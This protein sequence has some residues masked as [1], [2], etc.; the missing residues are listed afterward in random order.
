MPGF[1]PAEL[2]T[3]MADETLA[4]A[5]A[6]IW[7]SMPGYPAVLV[8]RLVEKNLVGATAHLLGSMPG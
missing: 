1:T 8:T 2:A 6:Y 4:D 3:R 7:G 5:T